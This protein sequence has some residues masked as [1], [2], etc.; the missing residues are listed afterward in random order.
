MPSRV[1]PTLQLGSRGDDVRK[2]QGYLNMLGQ[3]I[4]QDSV[5]G[6][7]TRQAVINFQAQAGVTPLD[8]IVGPRTWTAI[9]VNLGISVDVGGGGSPQIPEADDAPSDSG[10]TPGKILGGGLLLAG[11]AAL[12][13][14]GS[15]K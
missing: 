10:I 1:L 13:R 2:L 14:G 7:A 9:E 6:P 4:T 15:R 12:L 3:S 5:F 11:L 8:G